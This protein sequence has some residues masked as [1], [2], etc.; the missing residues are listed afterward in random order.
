[1]SSN[2]KPRN[3][4]E[5]KE[6]AESKPAEKDAVESKPSDDASGPV[7]KETEAEASAK[8]DDA[9]K[10]TAEEQTK[11]S[12]ST[13]DKPAYSPDFRAFVHFSALLFAIPLT[14]LAAWQGGFAGRLW[15]AGGCMVLVLFNLFGLLHLFPSIRRE[16]KR[17]NHGVWLYP[18]SLGLAFLV[19]PAYAVGA[20][21]AALAAGDAAATVLGRRLPKPELPWN[22]K[23]SWTGLLAF[24]LAAVPVCA[25]LLWWCPSPYFLALD[26]DALPTVPEWSYVWT[27]A[28]LGAFVGSI[29]ESLECPFDDNL[30]VVLGTG[31]TVW[32]ASEF[33]NL[34]TS[35]M[36]TLRAFQPE[37]LIHALIANAVLVAVLLSFRFV[38]L[39]G[40][41][42]GGI[43]G[44][45]IYFYT[46]WPGYL[47]LLLFVGLGSGVTR[48]G[49]TKK[50]KLRTAEDP[51]GKRGLP[52]V[53]ANLIVPLLCALAYAASR[54]HPAAL[55]A[56]AGALAAALADTTS[57]EIGTLSPSKPWLLTTGEP[58]SP[59]TNGGVSWLGYGAAFAALL[60]MVTVAW[61]S[62]FWR[63]VLEGHEGGIAT[64]PVRGTLLSLTIL[65]AG[66]AGTTVDSYLGATLEGRPG[67][68]NKH[69]V[70]FL[71]TL[72]GA[73][74]AG[75]IGLVLR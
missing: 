1:M 33:L 71:C 24:F 5:E 52:N 27:L 8:D 2:P 37:W 53:L 50:E 70:N 72:A 68:L 40:A 29:L 7:R 39:R 32:L 62:G 56:Y 64:D 55:W 35:G 31:L 26:A 13:D 9:E 41:I 43:I 45:L 69:G 54:G 11:D 67:G 46:L 49:R 12:G 51:S 75:A 28:A 63:I 3:D 66:V 15:A 30:R 74:I 57:S 42:A 25:L 18:F 60:L 36:P 14:W 19:F 4:P 73:L 47:L 65:A 20:A 58:V 21:W 44:T 6:A 38:N 16:G 10:E 23:K 17:V 34:S 22:K 59:G 61:L 48:Y